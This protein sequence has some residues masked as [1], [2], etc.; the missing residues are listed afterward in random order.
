MHREMHS[1]NNDLCGWGAVALA[2]ARFQLVDFIDGLK[3][4]RGVLH[5]L[6]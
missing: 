3:S 4:W 6:N 2:W 5:H 1:N